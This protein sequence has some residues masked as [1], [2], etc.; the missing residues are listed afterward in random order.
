MPR[1]LFGRAALILVLPVFGLQL[2]V[3]VAFIQRHFE[4]VTTQMTRS[5]SHELRYLASSVRAAPTLYQARAAIAEI[6]PPLELA[7]RRSKPRQ[8]SDNGVATKTP[9]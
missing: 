6:G 1:S 8:T 2:I 3:S 9:N 4:D 7:T 5:V